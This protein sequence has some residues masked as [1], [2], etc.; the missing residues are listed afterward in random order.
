MRG[1]DHQR[2]RAGPEFT[3]EGEKSVGDIACE[4]HSLLDGI[5]QDRKRAVFGTAFDLENAFDG[6]Q[7]EWVRGKAIEG[8]GGNTDNPAPLDKTRSIINNR[9]FRSFG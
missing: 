8:I 9:T 2:E 6:G 1:F 4:R 7:V 3:G 5:H